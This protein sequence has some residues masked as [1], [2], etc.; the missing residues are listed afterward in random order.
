M[1]KLISLMKKEWAPSKMCFTHI[2]ISF[3]FIFCHHLWLNP[4]S[5]SF[6]FV[7]FLT[8][9]Y[10]YYHTEALPLYTCSCAVKRV[11]LRPTF[12][13]L[14]NRVANKGKKSLALQRFLLYN[15]RKHSAWDNQKGPIEFMSKMTYYFL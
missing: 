15:H 3:T 14:L 6:L 11:C 4:S 1:K 2:A 12:V 8:T 7:C 10:G 13:T 5:C 9:R